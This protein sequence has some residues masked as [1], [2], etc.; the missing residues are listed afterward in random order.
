VTNMREEGM[1][2]NAEIVGRKIEKNEK[3]KKSNK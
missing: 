3:Q 2:E 1:G